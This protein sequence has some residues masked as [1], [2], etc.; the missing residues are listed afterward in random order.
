MNA[1]PTAHKTMSFDLKM[2]ITAISLCLTGTI[3]VVVEPNNSVCVVLGATSIVLG[4]IVWG[5]L[6]FKPRVK[7]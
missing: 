1:Q 3:L 4:M 7:A 2:R 5:I 6:V